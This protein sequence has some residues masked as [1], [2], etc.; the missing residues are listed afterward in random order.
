[1]ADLADMAGDYPDQMVEA[2]LANRAPTLTVADSADNCDECGFQ[3]PSDRQIIVP[4]TRHCAE[5][6]AMFEERGKHFE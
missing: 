1:M 3:I 4:G 6:A 5:C 2:A